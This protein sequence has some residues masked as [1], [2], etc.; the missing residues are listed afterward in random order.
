MPEPPFSPDSTGFFFAM[1]KGPAPYIIRVDEAFSK[2]FWSRLRARRWPLVLSG[3]AVLSA[4]ILIAIPLLS[5]RTESPRFSLDA[6]KKAIAEAR[7]SDAGRWA[8]QELLEA[9][10]ALRAA[11]IEHRRQETKFR[12]FRDYATARAGLRITEAKGLAARD[13]A[14]R[15]REEA[16]KAAEEAIA[17]ADE[18]VSLANSFA[19]A[20]HLEPAKR[21]LLQRTKIGVVEARYLK[22]A[23]ELISARER[24]DAVARQA[25]IVRESAVSLASRYTDPERMRVWRAWVEQTVVES[26]RGGGRAI[27]VSKERHVLTLFDDGRPLSHLRGRDGLQHGPGEAALRG[28]C[29]PGGTPS[30]RK[31]PGAIHPLQGSLLDYPNTEDRVRFDR[32]RRSGSILRWA[33]PGGLIEI[34]G[35]GRGGHWTKAA[36]RSRTRTWDDLSPGSRRALPVTIVG[37]DGRGGS[38]PT[39]SGRAERCLSPRP[40]RRGA[41]IRDNVD[42]AG[43]DAA[44][45]RAPR[46]SSRC[47]G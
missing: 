13:L 37:S 39:W 9:E 40:V 33:S 36:S 11:T 15:N 19:S 35:E 3:V 7:D 32:A 20:M 25:V 17:A 43:D 26:A 27:V 31:W 46:S 18:A 42:T 24:A 4:G 1:V 45:P 41:M 30:P 8:P 10:A 21:S 14:L 28:R 44:E 38:S 23:G 16:G 12:L 47:P 34:H 29:D 22:A 5:G 2:P 6:A